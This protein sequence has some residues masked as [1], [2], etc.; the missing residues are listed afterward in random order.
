MKLFIAGATGVL[1][2]RVVKRLIAGGH[3]VTGLSRS[4]AN[5][6]WLKEQGAEPRD[7]DLFDQEQMIKLVVGCEGVLHL[8]TAIPNK[9]RPTLADWALND[10]IRR[11]GTQNLIAAA[12]HN[13]CQLYVQ[14][15]ITFLYGDQQGAWVDETTPIMSQPGGVLQSA[16]D[17]EQMVNAA[18]QQHN[19]PAV[20]LRFG[21]FYSYDS[22][23]T[24]NMLSLTR[25]GWFPVIGDG[26]AYWNMINVDDAANAVVQTVNNYPQVLSHTF[27]ICDDEPV[28]YGDLVAYLAQ[29]LGARKP[30][31]LPVFLA[32]LLLGSGTVRFLL[33]S[34][35][36]RNQLAKEKL[37]WRPQYPTHREGFAAEIKKWRSTY[38]S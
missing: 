5:H 3:Q 27:N 1:G 23:Q 22:A 11:E 10:R 31:R 28:P 36:G 16:V 19:L 13:Q 38:A 17:M 2:K 26:Q 24:Q 29:T 20:I 6:A 18:A 35:R 32:N 14:Q 30:M 12:L 34:V 9:S 4:A 25:K 8:A 33:A 7:G 37:G 15:S 21:T